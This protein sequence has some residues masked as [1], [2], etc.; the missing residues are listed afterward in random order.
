MQPCMYIAH[1]EEPVCVL[2]RLCV[3]SNT[4]EH[5]NMQS[6]GMCLQELCLQVDRHG[7]MHT[8]SVLSVR[9]ITLSMSLWDIV[10]LHSWSEALTRTSGNKNMC[11]KERICN[12]YP[13]ESALHFQ[14]GEAHGVF[15]SASLWTV[16]LPWWLGQLHYYC[17]AYQRFVQFTSR[18]SVLSRQR[19]ALK[20]C[21]VC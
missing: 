6:E 17:P 13:S 7:C 12:E 14:D 10:G 16:S 9:S 15:L 2:A 1:L 11:M 8:K 19:E 21:N 5:T 18:N 4:V 20:K 3:C